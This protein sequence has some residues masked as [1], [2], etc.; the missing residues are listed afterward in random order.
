MERL[1]KVALEDVQKCFGIEENLFE[2]YYEGEILKNKDLV[3]LIGTRNNMQDWRE[4]TPLGGPGTVLNGVVLYSLIRHYELF[5]AV[6]TG[7]S[8]GFYTC[9]LLEAIS[10]QGGCLRSI[11]LS[12]DKTE[13]AKLVPKVWFKRPIWHLETGTNSLDSL[14]NE[15]DDYN[16]I[17]HLY[18]HDSLHTMSHMLQ[19]LME[20]KK[21]KNERF[22]VYIDDQD[23]DL[24]WRKCIASGAFNKP[25]YDVKYIS[26][27]E[28]RLNGH[29]GG[30]L[31]YEKLQ[32]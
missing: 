13:V 28:S 32:D 19:E 11:E 5:L 18:C 20:F 9:F 24:F 17:F 7:V 2:K 26:G 6:E 21:C 27:N 1:I 22:F 10:R 4:E 12:D 31:K 23:A 8:G 29:L 15:G 25:G 16:R 30:F 14:R 3:E